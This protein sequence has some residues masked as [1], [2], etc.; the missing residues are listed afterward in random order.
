MELDVC[1]HYGTFLFHLSI[2]GY[3]Y[4]TIV[5]K[6]F[7][8]LFIGCFGLTFLVNRGR[9][10][11]IGLVDQFIMAYGGLRGAVCYG[12]V[13]SLD[14]DLVPVKNMYVTTSVVVILLTVFVQVH[15]F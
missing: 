5:Q 10:E 2:D 12:L 13:M 8:K 1:H 6:L 7:E 9:V 4:I 15:I 11:K 3:V 14:A